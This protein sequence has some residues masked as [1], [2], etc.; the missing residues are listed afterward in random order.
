ML[1]TFSN[2][3]K[4]KGNSSPHFLTY[5]IP[6]PVW[7]PSSED[8][9]KEKKRKEIFNNIL[10]SKKKFLFIQLTISESSIQEAKIQSLGNVSKEKKRKR[11]LVTFPN[12][13]K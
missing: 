13:K 11:T 3:K 6:I 1:V 4:I 7:S 9:P 5:S 8:I 10:K 12:Q 2:Q